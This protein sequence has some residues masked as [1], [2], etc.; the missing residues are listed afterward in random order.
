MLTNEIIALL[1]TGGAGTAGTDILAGSL[2]EEP[3]ASVAVKQYGGGNGE[4]VFGG[5][6]LRIPVLESPRFQTR[7]RDA[8]QLAAWNKAR[9]CRDILRGYA[10]AVYETI[11]LLGDLYEEAETSGGYFVVSANYEAVKVPT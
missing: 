6:G 1:A 7:C 8:S 10:S 2:P 5:D 9:L 3:V 11:R 4:F